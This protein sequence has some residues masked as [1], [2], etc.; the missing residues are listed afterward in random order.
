MI[1]DLHQVIPLVNKNKYLVCHT[2]LKE[3][4]YSYSIQRMLNKRCLLQDHIE[5]LVIIKVMQPQELIDL[6]HKKQQDNCL[7][8][9]KKCKE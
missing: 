7:E 5:T 4:I 2:K 1:L 9:Y 3:N 6:K 8:I